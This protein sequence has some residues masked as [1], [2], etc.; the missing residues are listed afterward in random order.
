[1][2]NLI[3]RIGTDI[4]NDSLVLE[5]TRNIIVGY[6]DAMKIKI[7]INFK[8]K[9]CKIDIHQHKKGKITANVDL[10]RYNQNTQMLDIVKGFTIK[11]VEV[12]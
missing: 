4:F 8:Y 10:S 7:I 3:F 5:D 6:L 2:A 1:M 12:S 9:H 11:H